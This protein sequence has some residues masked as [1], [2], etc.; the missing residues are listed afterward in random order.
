MV[1]KVK[2]LGAAIVAAGLFAGA[3]PAGAEECV[4]VKGSGGC[5]ATLQQAVDAA[6][7][8]EAIRVWPGWY[9]NQQVD[10]NKNGLTIFGA[11][12]SPSAVV[13]DGGRLVLT[14][15]ISIT[16]D[17]VTL[18][19]LSV[20][21]AGENLID[22]SG[23]NAKI[24]KVWA[25]GA[26]SE[27][28]HVKGANARIVGSR[29]SLTSSECVLV[30]ADNFFMKQTRVASCSSG[31][32]DVAGASPTLI[33]NSAWICENASGVII[34][35]ANATVRGN[36]VNGSESD[37]LDVSGDSPQVIGN[38]L[39]G[40]YDNGIILDASTAMTVTGNSVSS[41]DGNAVDLTCTGCTGPNTVSK[42]VISNTIE[43]DDGFVIDADGPT[44]ILD[45]KAL[46]I[47][48]YGFDITG[49]GPFT[50]RGNQ[51]R[52]IGGDQGERGFYIH[53]TNNAVVS[54]NIATNV[55]GYGFEFNNVGSST[56]R[57]NTVDGCWYD[58]FV[59]G[60]TSAGNTLESNV[61]RNCLEAG[62]Q[63][64]SGASGTILTSNRTILTNYPYC[65]QGLGTTLTG[66]NFTTSACP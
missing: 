20:R 23:A 38:D 37:C 56:L 42:N 32:I 53:G 18:R 31:C 62:F 45:N 59:V 35:G 19:N 13:I 29:V 46:Y 55:L 39:D 17:N 48:D 7:V 24:L 49:A 64:D 65:D 52:D 66:N 6:S 5:F 33:S 15:A 34:A 63:L 8:G 12:R 22:V 21:N 51:A 43:D 4:N 2:I 36:K 27:G 61:V 30:G 3:F 54:A 47:Q 50:I 40:C 44:Q 11:G 41:T 28:I 25:T 16:A 1:V 57:G 26:D 60:G 14:D 9:K 10:V 58:G